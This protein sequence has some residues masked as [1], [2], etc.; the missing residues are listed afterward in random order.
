MRVVLISTYELGHQPFGLAS[1]AAWLKEAGAAVTCVDLAVEPFGR[2]LPTIR[3]ADLIAFYLPMHTATRLATAVIPRTRQLNPTAHLCAYGLYAPMNEPYLRELGIQSI[4][5]G[6]FEGGL[7][8]LYT[9]LAEG[10]PIELPLI[11]LARQPFRQPERSGLPELGAYATLQVA[12][13][14]RLVGYTEASRGCKHSCRHCPIVPVYDGRFRIIQ[15]DIVLADIRQQVTAGAQ[16]ITFG[17]PDF[18]NGPTHA[19]RLIKALHNEFPALTYDA[20]IKIEHLLAQANLLPTL[21]DTGCLFITSAVEAVDDHILQIFDKRH[22]RADF[23]QVVALCRDVGLTLL[24]T[25]VSFT[26]WTTRQGYVD[27]LAT[28]AE[29]GLV[30][31]V[32]PVQLAIRLLIPAGSKL[33]DLAEV[34]GLVRPFDPTALVYPWLH[35]DPCMDELYETVFRLVKASQRAAEPRRLTFARIWQAA[36]ALLPPAQIPPLPHLAK[37]Q[38][39]PPSLSE[40]WY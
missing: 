24:P 2:A 6:E 11:S 40:E 31:Q 16:H 35:P 28:I 7:V 32:S 14:R 9:G 17:D 29:L 4:L 1:P 23:V 12:G 5:G 3:Q 36:T 20:T 27:L 39:T 34:R 15:P 19:L 25:F 13:E 26:P 30:E 18:F 21:R 10:R 37:A 33:L 38:S 8:D 22:T